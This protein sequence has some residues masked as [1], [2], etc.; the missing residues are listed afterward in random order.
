M[1]YEIPYY[2]DFLPPAFLTESIK[3]MVEV[4]GVN[5]LL[6]K[7]ELQSRFSKIETPEALNFVIS[8][9][10]QV[11]ADLNL[12]LD[13]RGVDRALIDEKVL[14]CVASNTKNNIDYLD[15]DYKTVLG[16]KDN[17]G[18]LVIGP[19]ET[20]CPADWKIDIPKYLEGDQVTLF[21]PPDTKKM[22][23]NAMNA[24]H[25][26][27]PNEPSIVGE[28]VDTTN[29]FPKWGADNEDSKTPLMSDFLLACENLIEC[30]DGSLKFDDPNNGK[31]YRM[32]SDRLS[33]PI[34]RF[35][36]LA[37][38]DLAHIYQGSPLPLHL[39]D[40]AMHMFHNWKIP[41]AL[42]FYVPKLE[43]EEEAKYIHTM[44]HTCEKMLKKIYPDYVMGQ[45]KLYI[46]FEGPRAIF[47][48]REIAKALHPYFVG[49]SLGWHD[50]LAATARILKNDPNYRIPV[51]ADPNIVIKHIRESHKILADKLGPIGAIKLGGMYGILYEA[52]N[53]ESFQI[54]MIGYIKDVVTQMKRGL[55]GFWVAHPDFVRVGFAMVEAYRRNDGSLEKLARALVTDPQDQKDLVDFINGPDVEGLDKND[56]LYQRGVIAASLK[57]SDVIAN[58]DPEELRYNIF[59]AVQYLADWLN[60]NGCVALPATLRDRSG[61]PI[62]VRIMDDLATT[63]RSRW[64]VWAEIHHGRVSMEL[65]EKILAEE[66]QFIK[67]DKITDERAVQV[68]WQGELVKW[69]PV[70]IQLL[71]KLMTDS[72][73]VEFVP[74]L[75]LPFLCD[76]VR[77]SDD[78]WSVANKLAPEIYT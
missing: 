61:K 31:S 15:P 47:R 43:N 4:E 52:R 59:Q 48:I 32:E 57:E 74:Q 7:K 1:K 6:T 10:N 72:N 37:I 54:S 39:Y 77:D 38:P 27:L 25:R 17:S 19:H 65:F 12:I 33:Q 66:I 13:R 46:V 35:P 53:E 9:Y 20:E 2:E 50:F 69:Y 55:D 23:I 5:G 14:E 64:E 58:N 71:R 75:L 63:E 8:L 45:V 28:L 67:E 22:S 68:K 36:G 78:P 51:K 11:K 3:S 62:R 30:F 70:A 76:F 49:G 73:P 24:I 42:C 16:L 41:K 29:Q 56:P 40:F 34:K 21:G 26:K 18:R 60:G 44:I